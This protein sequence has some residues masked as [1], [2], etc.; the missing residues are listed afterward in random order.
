MCLKILEK[1]LTIL[2]QELVNTYRKLRTIKQ[3]TCTS[4]NFSLLS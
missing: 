2:T 3:D 1:N 4:A